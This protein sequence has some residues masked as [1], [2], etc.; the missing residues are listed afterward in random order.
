FIAHNLASWG[1]KPAG[2]E[3]TYFQRVPLRMTKIDPDKTN[4]EINGQSYVYGKDFLASAIPANLAGV[5]MVFAGN[6]WVIKSKNIDPYKGIDVKDKVVVVVNS[7]PKGVT[8]ADLQGPAGVYWMSPP[9]YAKKNGAKAV[10]AFS[11][12]GNLANW[13]GTVWTQSEKGIVE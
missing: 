1:I 3:G 8:F 11:T 6:G 2:D 13:E 9:L 7:L 5:P 4:L 12:F 10:I